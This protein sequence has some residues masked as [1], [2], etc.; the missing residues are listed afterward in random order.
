MS[1]TH[2]LTRLM[3]GKKMIEYRHICTLYRHVLKIK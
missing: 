2:S 3:C 1:L